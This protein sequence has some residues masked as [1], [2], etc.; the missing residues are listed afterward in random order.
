MSTEDIQ[1]AGEFRAALE[2]AAQTGDRET[3]H[4]LLAPEIEWVTPKRTLRGIDEVKEE[5]TWGAPAEHLDLEFEQGD[6]VDLGDGHVSCD[7]RQIYRMKES[8]EFA[9]ERER[10]IDLMIREGKIHRYEMRI[11]G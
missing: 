11:V 10:H 6:W 3:V 4:A 1:L 7:V 2:V 9:Y 8:G 5:L